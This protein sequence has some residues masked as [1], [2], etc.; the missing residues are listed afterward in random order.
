M[1]RLGGV[2]SA[3]GG[4]CFDGPPLW[5]VKTTEALST[6]SILETI[7]SFALKSVSELCWTLADS[8]RQCLTQHG[9]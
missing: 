9:G 8:H 6:P 2:L 4:G 7:I 5:A 1:V 3:G